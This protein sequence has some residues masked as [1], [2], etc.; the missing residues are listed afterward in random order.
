MSDRKE[1]HRQEIIVGGDLS[2]E[3]YNLSYIV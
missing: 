1:R 2:D 3:Y